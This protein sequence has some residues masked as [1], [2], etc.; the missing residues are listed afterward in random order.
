MLLTN[1]TL[2]FLFGRVQHRRQVESGSLLSSRQLLQ[3]LVRGAPVQ[4]SCANTTSP[5]DS[6]K[7]NR[8]NGWEIFKPP[9]RS[10]ALNEIL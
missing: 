8:Q 2:S 5:D 1:S 7:F 6:A 3:N 9:A 10:F 4:S